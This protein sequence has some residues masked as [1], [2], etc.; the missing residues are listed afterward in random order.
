MHKIILKIRELRNQGT[1]KVSTRLIIIFLMSLGLYV[2]TMPL[3]SPT[4]DGLNDK[5]IHMFVFFCFAMLMDLAT[6]RKPSWLWKG[7][8]LLLYGVLIEV[9]Q[10]MTPYRGFEIADMIANMSGVFMYFSSKMMI[11]MLDR[12]V[13][14]IS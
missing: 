14:K 6:S 3:T 13:D 12:A 9:L 10:S 8:P 7:L 4:L 11:K 2:G 5:L 1:F